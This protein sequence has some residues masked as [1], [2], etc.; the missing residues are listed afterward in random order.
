MGFPDASVGKRIHLQSRDTGN[1][2]SAPG[3]R[4]SPGGGHSNSVQY[5]C[6]ENPMNRGAWQATVHGVAELDTAERLFTHLSYI[7]KS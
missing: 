2:G 5:S 7:N 1:M 4:R 6:L 3:S